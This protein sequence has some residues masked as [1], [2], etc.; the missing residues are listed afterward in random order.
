MKERY[1]S[2]ETRVLIINRDNQKCRYC[3]RSRD[4]GI[5]LTVDHIIP[6]SRGG[7]DD[8]GNLWTLCSDCNQGKDNMILKRPTKE[9]SSV[10]MPVPI[11]YSINQVVQAL[12]HYKRSIKQNHL[13]VYQA[14][15]VA[16]NLGLTNGIDP[17]CYPLPTQAIVGALLSLEKE[18]RIT[19]ENAKIDISIL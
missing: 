18:G 4:D 10:G 16:Q 2:K 11:D 15:I 17:L 1:V 14:I 19:I 12:Q 8:L 3:G 6:F 7:T 13:S 5:K 9:I